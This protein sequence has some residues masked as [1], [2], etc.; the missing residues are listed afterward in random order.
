[1]QLIWQRV[2]GATRGHYMLH[3]KSLHGAAKGSNDVITMSISVMFLSISLNGLF[4]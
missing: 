4:S 3:R 2:Y 1:M